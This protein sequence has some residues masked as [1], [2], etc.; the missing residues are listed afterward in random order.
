MEE[1]MK[2]EIMRLHEHI[3]KLEENNSSKS[4]G[5]V[6]TRVGLSKEDSCVQEESG[7]SEISYASS[8]NSETSLK[9]SSDRHSTQHLLKRRHLIILLFHTITYLERGPLERFTVHACL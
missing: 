5:I 1:L 8:S 9:P 2:E 6:E 3:K 4:I 7:N